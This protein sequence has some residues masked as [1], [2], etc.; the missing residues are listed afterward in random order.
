MWWV[1]TVSYILSLTS[2]NLHL[3]IPQRFF[4]HMK[5]RIFN[6]PNRS[7]LQS[8][9]VINHMPQ[10]N[11]IAL[12]CSEIW[13]STSGITPTKLPFKALFFWSISA[14]GQGSLDLKAA[15]QQEATLKWMRDW[16]YLEMLLCKKVYLG[17]DVS[18]VNST[19]WFNCSE[20]P[21]C[22]L[23]CFHQTWLLTW[24]SVFY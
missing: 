16:G 8:H 3:S 1:P 19:L 12:F 23:F 15:A 24:N 10:I 2:T 13:W 14:E 17:F 4:L 18:R 5:K 11:I 9:C 20:L 6:C 21:H 7:K 22:D